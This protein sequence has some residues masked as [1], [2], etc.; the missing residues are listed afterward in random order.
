MSSMPRTRTEF[1]IHYSAL[2][3][4]QAFI[5]EHMQQITVRSE[6]SAAFTSASSIPQGLVLEPMLNPTDFGNL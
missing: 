2:D 4:L 3:Q 5:T 1:G 6:K